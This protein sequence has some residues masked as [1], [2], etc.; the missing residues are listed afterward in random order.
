MFEIALGVAQGNDY[1]HKGCEMQI[2]H[3]DIKPH[4]ILLDENFTPKVSDFGLANLYSVDDDIISLTAARDEG[5]TMELGDVTEIEN[6]IMRKM[7]IVTL[8][9]IQMKPTDRPSMSKVLKMLESEVELLEMPPKP[10][11]SG[12]I[13]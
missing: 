12:N 8:W 10:S 4:N 1:L 2:L 11:F 9:C 5:D 13:N 6:K 3:F 7:V